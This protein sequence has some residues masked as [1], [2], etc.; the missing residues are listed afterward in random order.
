MCIMKVLVFSDSHSGL[1]FMRAAIKAVSPDAMI[2]LGDYYADGDT[3]AFENPSVPMYL[4]PGN[5][6]KYRV[7]GKPEAL[8]LS[9]FGAKLYMVHGHNEG[10]KMTLSRLIADARA[11][12]AQ[13]ALYGHTHKADR[14][15]EEGGLWVINPGSCE[16]YGGSAAVIIIE[17]GKIDSCRLITA[18]MLTW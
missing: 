16:S 2:H 7:Q 13:A 18:D 17:E 11:A 15:R 4:V 3:I 5:C 6:D 8:C 9:I 10:V 14:H 12:G 1:S